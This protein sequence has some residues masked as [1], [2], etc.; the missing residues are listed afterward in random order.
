MMETVTFQTEDF[1]AADRF[2]SWCE[3]MTQLMG[4]MEMASEHAPDFQ[5]RARVLQLGA[6]QVW[7]MALQPMQFRRTV[8]LLRESASERYHISLV[9]S[10]ALDVRQDG[11]HA[12]HGRHDLSV[13]DL[14]RPFDCRLIG[15]GHL[16]MIGVE[17]PKVLLPLP[18][19]R[20]EKLLARRLPGTGGIGALLV[21]VITR[22]CGE[23]DGYRP[24]DG[25]RLS[26]VLVD[27][28][29]ALLA[30]TLDAENV[31]PSGTH[32]RTRALRIRAFIQRHLHDPGLTVS[33][34][35]AAH[36]ISVSYL[37]RLFE[38]EG[39]TVAAWIREQR[40][41][42]IRRDLADPA[43][44][45]TPIHEVANRW[46]FADP[47]TFSRTFRSVYGISPKDYRRRHTH[48][49]RPPSDHRELLGQG[50]V[51]EVADRVW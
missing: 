46:G 6:L 16:A 40:L 41:G 49:G 29:S 45:T 3:R 5:A 51:G 12:V 15:G 33:T 30:H 1:P 43:L 25:P 2:A 11:G 22:L 37:H 10:G 27:L 39:V 26:G 8:R 4:P 19:Q 23:T 36:H 31:L 13:V 35:A 24:A 42:R 48:G 9:L 50:M 34:I 17:I 7:P 14:S 18:E 38:T 20:V 21:G 44:A 32:R 28:L 47:A